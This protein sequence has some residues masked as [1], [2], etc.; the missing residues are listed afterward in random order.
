MAEA[1]QTDHSTLKTN[2]RFTKDGFAPKLVEIR[3]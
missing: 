2:Y 3:T 1:I